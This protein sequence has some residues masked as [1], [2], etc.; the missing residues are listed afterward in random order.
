M[1]KA[2]NNNRMSI[3]ATERESISAAFQVLADYWSG[4]EQME[5][6]LIDEAELILPYAE[7][8]DP[9]QPHLFKDDPEK[10]AQLERKCRQDAAQALVDTAADFGVRLPIAGLTSQKW[11]AGK[12]RKDDEL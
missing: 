9:P 1:A 12:R 5:T 11:D 2:L 10:M 4:D 7:D 3:S 8:Y 6:L